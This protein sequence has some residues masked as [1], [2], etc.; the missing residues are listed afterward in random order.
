MMLF[1]VELIQ[2]SSVSMVGFFYLVNEQISLDR[3]AWV[4][5]QNFLSEDSTHWYMP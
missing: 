4:E 3:S 1:T 5:W 2:R